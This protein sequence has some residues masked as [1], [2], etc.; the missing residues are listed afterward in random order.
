MV[1]VSDILDGAID[2]Q[3]WPLVALCI[4]SN[5][6]SAK[7]TH[8]TIEPLMSIALYGEI[9]DDARQFLTRCVALIEAMENDAQ[10]SR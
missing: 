8:V 3:D 1:K 10:I 4:L 7:L 5:P 6:L 9:P 2:G